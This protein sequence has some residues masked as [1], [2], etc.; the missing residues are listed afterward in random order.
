MGLAFNS[1]KQGEVQFS[2]YSTVVSSE[3]AGNRF[4][5]MTVYLAVELYF[6]WLD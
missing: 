5:F 2:D 6:T 4:A 1:A 3:V